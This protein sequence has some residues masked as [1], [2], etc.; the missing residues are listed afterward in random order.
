MV[1]LEHIINTLRARIKNDNIYRI[2]FIL[3]LIKE[4]LQFL[5][6]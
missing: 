3:L 2:N 5:E 4:F 1:K 6:D